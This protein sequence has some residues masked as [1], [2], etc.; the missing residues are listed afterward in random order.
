MLAH[1]HASQWVKHKPTLDSDKQAKPEH[2]T[3]AG[4]HE[5]KVERTQQY[6]FKRFKKSPI[7]LNTQH[8]IL[9][10][11]GKARQGRITTGGV[12]TK[13]SPT[14]PDAYGKHGRRSKHRTSSSNHFATFRHWAVSVRLTALKEQHKGKTSIRRGAVWRTEQSKS[15]FDMLI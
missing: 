9:M 14:G 7:K 4:H 12:F 6:L 10:T 5:G 3:P 1:R 2:S 8:V 15:H 11:Y 13:F